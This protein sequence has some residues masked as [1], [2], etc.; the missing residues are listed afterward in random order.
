M[1]ALDFFEMVGLTRLLDFV[2]TVLL[3]FV[4]G[5]WHPMYVHWERFAQ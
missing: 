2:A 5:S 1:N 3:M 4:E